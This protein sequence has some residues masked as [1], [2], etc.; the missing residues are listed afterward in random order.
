M[1]AAELIHKIEKF[2]ELIK[3]FGHEN[4]NSKTLWQ[5]KSEITEHF[6]A[7]TFTDAEEKQTTLT[8]F[9]TLAS[10]LKEKQDLITHENEEFA[11]NAEQQ[12]NE[13]EALV[14]DG[15]YANSPDK[16]AILN[17][18]TLTDKTFENFKQSRW[19][20]KER[21]TAA[22][23]KFN[24]LREKL[25][26]EEDAY[27]TTL[28]KKKNERINLSQQ[29]SSILIEVIESCH[30]DASTNSLYESLKQL[31]AHF[32][33]NGAEL[34]NVEWIIATKEAEPKSSLKMKSEGLRDVRRVL[35]ENQ[36]EITREDKQ[37]IYSTLEA[38]G[39]DLNKTW[40]THRAEMQKKQEEWEE[41]KKQNEL[42]RADWLVKQ[43]DFLNVLTEKLEKRTTDKINLER[44]LTNKKDF[45][46]RQQAR[47]ANQREFLK[48]ISDDLADMQDKLN[49]AW[50]DSFKERM[51]EKVNQKET[52]I[53]EVKKDIEEVASKLKEVDKDIVDISEKVASIEKSNEELK[54]KIEEVK[55]NL[56]Q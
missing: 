14:K 10:T 16:D 21:R 15:F 13:I 45:Q 32:V 41:R 19:P 35:N 53:A 55:K 9:E 27:Y 6:R 51:A 56:E 48:K 47:L 36:E 31:V 38:I 11:T 24:T 28:R 3:A 17:L 49:T 12:I 54:L 22:W 43:T 42:K 37:K 1:T 8:L 26:A 7:T 50:T 34:A 4:P 30:P 5:M 2:D 18:K 25:R 40:E 39:S 23:D 33:S 29:L 46:G 20:S 52:K 44:I